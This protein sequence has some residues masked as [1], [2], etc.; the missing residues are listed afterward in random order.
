MSAKVK[1]FMMRMIVLFILGIGF[2]SFLNIE[3]IRK[4][5]KHTE[6]D[7]IGLDRKVT[8]YDCSGREIRSWTGRF[9]IEQSGNCISFIDSK[10]KEIKL[11]GTFIIEEQ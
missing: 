10:N 6:S 4:K 11:F 3:H 5:I 1:A 7:F 2:Y 8:L 9:R